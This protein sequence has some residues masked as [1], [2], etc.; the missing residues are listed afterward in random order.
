MMTGEVGY[1][2]YIRLENLSNKVNFYQRVQCASQH[3]NGG[4]HIAVVR[5]E[6]MKSENILC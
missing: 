4:Y 6:N 5:S 2:R 3:I 1:Y